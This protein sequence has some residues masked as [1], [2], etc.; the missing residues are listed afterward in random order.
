MTETQTITAAADAV[1]NKDV[2][3]EVEILHPSRMERWQKKL[4]RSFKI[5]PSTLGT[6]IKI[7]KEFLSVDLD[8]FDKEEIMKSSFLLIQDHAERMAMIVAFAVVNAKEDPPASL[9]SFFLNNLTAK[10]LAG[11][12]SI[13]LTQIDT[14]NFLKSIISAKGVNILSKMNPQ[15]KGSTLAPGKPL[16]A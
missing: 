13:I 9:V 14:V 11:L 10:E 1:L 16:E 15:T 12:V 3:F 2:T 4:K 6:M 8:N 7:S 5:T